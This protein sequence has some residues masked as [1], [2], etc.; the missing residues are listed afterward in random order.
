MLVRQLR[1]I[2]ERLGYLPREEIERFSARLDVP[3]HRIHE[4][5]SFFPHLRLNP[6]RMLRLPS[7]GTSPATSGRRRV[8]L[9]RLRRLPVN[10]AARLG[11]RSKVSRAWDAATGARAVSIELHRKGQPEQAWVLERRGE[12]LRG[13]MRHDRRGASRWPRRATR[14][15]RLLPRPWRIDPYH[16]A[17]D[18]NASERFYQAARELAAKLN[19]AASDPDRLAVRTSLIS[20]LEQANLRGMGARA[21]R[22][23][24]NGEMFS[25]PAAM[26]STSF[27]TPT[28]AS[29]R[30]SRTARCCCAPPT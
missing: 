13:A 8:A 21:R 17:A 24:R 28:R 12:R 23:R 19:V 29:R 22:P 2:Q 27:A 7:A 5:I 10:S 30:R 1:A 18:A 15:R 16:R 11:P 6:R 4:V 25:R 9:R 14:C 20:E 3:L 26:K